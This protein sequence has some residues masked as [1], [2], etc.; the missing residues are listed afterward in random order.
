MLER[1]SQ[2]KKW[3]KSSTLTAGLLALI[4]NDIHP[5]VTQALTSTLRGGD[6]NL[7]TI[8]L[9]IVLGSDVCLPKEV[10]MGAVDVVGPPK[11]TPIEMIDTADPPEEIMIEMVDAAGH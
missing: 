10:S 1:A 2:R 3:A 7:P 9:P 8:L 11:E 6:A 4:G 5:L